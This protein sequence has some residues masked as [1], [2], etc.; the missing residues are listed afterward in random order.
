[1][2]YDSPTPEEAV[3]YMG[4]MFERLK[5]Q[6]VE[7][8]S[9]LD[10]GAAHG[11]F[12]GY[13]TKFY[14]NAEIVAVECN[15]R[16]SYFLSRYRWE[17]HYKCLGATPGVQ[18]FYIDRNSEIGGGSS[19]YKENT[20]HF[21]NC[22]EESKEI[23]TLDHEFAD[24]AFDFI[25]ID[26]QGSELDIM[27]GGVNVVSRAKWLLLELSFQEYNNGAPLIDDVLQYTRS[28]GWRMYD[29]IGPIDGGHMLHGDPRKLQVDVLLRNTLWTK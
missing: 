25:K 26:T 19:L 8:K 16:D 24:R 9:L 23:T 28:I 4:P 12:S 11:H 10:V 13:F 29:T 21:N 14:P 1:M 17:T 7:I 15:T 20:G 5:A 3:G 27:K 2:N 18:T 22:I 6:G